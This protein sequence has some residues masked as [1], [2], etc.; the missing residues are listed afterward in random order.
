MMSTGPSG[1]N[2]D[3]AAARP[4][5]GTSWTSSPDSSG[6]SMTRCRRR[7][8]G[9]NSQLQLFL[10]SHR[11][12]RPVDAQYTWWFRAMTLRVA[13]GLLSSNRM[14]FSTMSSS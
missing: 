9:G 6:N 1:M 11:G 4:R 2:G 5:S 13:P 7:C 3:R 10:P 14:K 12:H 8:S